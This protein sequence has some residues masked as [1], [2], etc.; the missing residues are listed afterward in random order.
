[1]IFFSGHLQVEKE[2]RHPD[3]LG[4]VKVFTSFHPQSACKVALT[5]ACGTGYEY[6]KVF[7]D[8]ITCGESKY[9][10]L[11]KL[12][13]GSIVYINYTCFRLIEAGVF[14]QSLKTVA[15]AT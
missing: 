6:V 14:D 12:S 10:I 5:T 7:R 3:I 15:L 4:I 8:I 1:M 2:I 13:S 9:K 11:V